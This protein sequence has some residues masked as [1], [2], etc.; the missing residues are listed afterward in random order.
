MQNEIRGVIE[1]LLSD[2]SKASLELTQVFGPQKKTYQLYCRQYGLAFVKT[3][4]GRSLAT[5][6]TKRPYVPHPL[7]TWPWMAGM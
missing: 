7:A 6:A 5:A 2:P 4:R 1:Q 3:E